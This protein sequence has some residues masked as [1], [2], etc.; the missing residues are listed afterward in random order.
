MR[1]SAVVPFSLPNSRLL[2]N[3][4]EGK[5][6]TR[7]GMFSFFY[8]HATVKR[9][10]HLSSRASLT[11]ADMLEAYVNMTVVGTIINCVIV[12]SRGNYPM[13]LGTAA[14]VAR[15]RLIRAN[16]HGVHAAD[17]ARIV[18]YSFAYLLTY[19]KSQEQ[20]HSNK[21]FRSPILVNNF[22]ET[23]QMIFVTIVR[24]EDN[25]T[26]YIVKAIQKK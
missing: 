19:F 18:T 5:N 23:A 13:T 24:C 15:F 4:T 22:L 1:T 16:I 7:R 14:R 25:F 2:L 6:I 21:R 10:W 9:R 3:R 11:H 8:Y 17:G 20:Y 26:F 12:N